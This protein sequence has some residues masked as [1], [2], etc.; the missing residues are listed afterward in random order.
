MLLLQMLIESF[1]SRLA[2]LFFYLS[3]EFSS[4]ILYIYI[5]NFELLFYTSFINIIYYMILLIIIIYEY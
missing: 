3:Y 4:L 2:Q 1:M 5:N